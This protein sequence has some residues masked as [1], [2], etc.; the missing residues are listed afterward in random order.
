MLVGGEV[1][2]SV[3]VFVEER[4]SSSPPSVETIEVDEDDKEIEQDALVGLTQLSR[5]FL[6]G[7]GT[8]SSSLP[9]VEGGDTM[10]ETFFIRA[11]ILRV[12]AVRCLLFMRL[13]RIRISTI[14]QPFSWSSIMLL[15]LLLLLLCLQ[16]I[17]IDFPLRNLVR[18]GI[19]WT[20]VRVVPG[21]KK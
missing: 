4:D 17:I 14:E 1:S 8:P 18:L 21:R 13:T 3:V 9:P 11:M 6:V 10:N 16:W 12:T 19:L 2:F 7:G 15:L 5:G 20:P